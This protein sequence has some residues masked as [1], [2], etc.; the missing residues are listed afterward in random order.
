M[1]DGLISRV[2][3]RARKHHS[4]DQ[5]GTAIEP[6]TV[7]KRERGVWEGQPYVFKAHTDCEAAA[8]DLWKLR[9]LRWD[10]G[11]NLRSDIEPEDHEWLLAEHPSVAARL[12]VTT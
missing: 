9:D 10:E 11:I 3:Q 6:G 8:H 12:R 5:C 4:C 1:S 2:N 7:Y